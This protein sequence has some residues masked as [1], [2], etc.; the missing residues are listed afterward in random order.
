[1]STF[2]P[3]IVRVSLEVDGRLKVL[4]GLAVVATGTKYDNAIQNECEVRIANLDKTTRDFIL[5][6]TSPL[7]PLRVPRRIIVEAGRESWGT[8]QLIEGDII[9]ATVSPPPDIWLTVKAL[10]GS[11]YNG[12]IVSRSQAAAA[13]VSAIAQ[14]VAS[15]LGLSLNFQAT[16]KNVTNWS[17]TGGAS[18]QVGSLGALGNFSAF[19]DDGT[20]VVKNKTEPLAGT[21]KIV[22]KATGMIGVPEVSPYGVKVKYLID[23]TSKIGGAIQV[24][25]EINPTANGVYCI[26]K[27]SFEVASRDTPFYYVAEGYRI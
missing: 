14:G 19:V 17:F 26:Y 20:L 5:T 16:D 12:E 6:E 21:L 4:E 24:E 10:T 15:D 3:R 7:N 18:K 2:D 11:Y 9:A 25:S 13:P 8:T 23:N 27:L 1:M 22:N